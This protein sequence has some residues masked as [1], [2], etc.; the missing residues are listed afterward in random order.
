M[1]SHREGPVY[2]VSF[3]GYKRVLIPAPM[4]K[5]W[6]KKA[7]HQTPLFGGVLKTLK[8]YQ[9]LRKNPLFWPQRPFLALFSPF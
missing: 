4:P 7:P 9:K 8:L 3:G 2:K 5:I 1:G 6:L